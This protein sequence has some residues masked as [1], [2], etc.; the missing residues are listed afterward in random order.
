MAKDSRK[1]EEQTAEAPKV[2][3]DNHRILTTLDQV[4]S[5]FR[6]QLQDEA[7]KSFDRAAIVAVET[8]NDIIA[9]LKFKSLPRAL[10]IAATAISSTEIELTWKD[11]TFEADG[12]KVKRCEGQYCEDL[13]GVGRELLPNERSFKDF[14]L[15][16]STTYRYQVVTFNGRGETPSQIVDVTT[17]ASPSQT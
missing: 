6:S 1:T 15:S 7:P 14:N 4:F 3:S 13:I 10:Q 11:D 2:T 8:F 9:G 12:Y 5:T 17:L 16:S